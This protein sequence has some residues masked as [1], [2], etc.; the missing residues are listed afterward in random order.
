MENNHEPHLDEHRLS[1]KGDPHPIL[2]GIV[3]TK[4]EMEAF[5]SPKNKES[6][7]HSKMVVETTAKVNGKPAGGTDLN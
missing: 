2:D 4:V 7:S 3:P 6:R 1:K 5:D